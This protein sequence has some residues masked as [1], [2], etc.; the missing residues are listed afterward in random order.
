MDGV[1][2]R[3]GQRDLGRADAAVCGDLV[4]GVDDR[5]VEGES[6]D[7]ATSSNGGAPRPFT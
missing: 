4:D 3:P 1:V 5:L 2:E 7:L 6:K